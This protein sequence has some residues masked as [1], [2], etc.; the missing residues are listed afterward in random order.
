MHSMAASRGWLA[1]RCGS[2]PSD[3]AACYDASAAWER[4]RAPIRG[5]AFLITCSCALPAP[6]P[7]KRAV[8]R[9]GPPVVTAATIKAF[10]AH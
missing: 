9:T 6:L 7:H 10:S 4:L 8:T 1:G 3:S 5:S 2:G